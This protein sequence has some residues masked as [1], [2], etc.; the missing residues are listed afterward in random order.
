MIYDLPTTVEIDGEKYKIRNKCDYRIALDT[1]GALNDTVL[2]ENERIYCAVVIFYEE[3]EKIIVN[4]QIYQQAILE[5]F[6]IL[7]NGEESDENEPLSPKKMDWEQDFKLIAPPVSR[8]L[9]YSVRSE[10][11]THW[12]DFIGAYMEIGE[13]LFANI[14]SIRE[15]RIKGKKLDKIEQEFYDENRKLVDLK[16]LTEDEIEWL[17]MMD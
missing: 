3:Y 6:K 12:Y 2:K 15:K 14:V 7:N 11:Y 9:G 1:I 10:K 17:N 16:T 5:M 8:V 4:E 13:C